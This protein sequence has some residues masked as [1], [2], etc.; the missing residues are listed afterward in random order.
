MR[1]SR[2]SLIGGAGAAGA[3][4][5]FAGGARYDESRA[6]QPFDL[7]VAPTYPFR[8]E[9]QAGIV[10]PA[11]DRLHFA[12]FDVTTGSR[13]ALVALLR[14]C[15]PAAAR[16]TQGLPVGPVGPTQGDPFQPPDDTGEAIGLSP[17]GLTITFGF[18]PGL[19]RDADGR[20][21]FGLA[22]RQPAAPSRLRRLI[23]WRRVWSS[24]LIGNSSRWRPTGRRPRPRPG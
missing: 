5:G 6:E 12:A 7:A 24:S 9:R 8:G 15:T 17:G 14:A 22:D 2:R 19:F 10:T 3:V 18:G 1:V 13:A 23:S 21:R 16:M 11:Q 20:D 4:V